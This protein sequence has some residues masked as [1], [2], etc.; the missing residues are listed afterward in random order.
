MEFEIGKKYNFFDDGKI[1][2]S[3]HYIAEVTDII[4]FNKFHM[5]TY[6]NEVIQEHLDYNPIYT[7]NPQE[8]IVCT[9]DNY[10]KGQFFFI[11]MSDNTGNYFSVNDVYW[12][13]KL[14]TKQW[15]LEN[16]VNNKYSNLEL[17]KQLVL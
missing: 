12:D 8:V 15:C 10:I 4:P 16:I 9:I 14:C 5:R 1:C 13:G 2:T 7:E 17:I 11:K 3:R 6:I